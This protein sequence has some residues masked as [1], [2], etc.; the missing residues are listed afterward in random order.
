MKY[1]V[2]SQ[3]PAGGIENIHLFSSSLS[4][5]KMAQNICGPHFKQRIVAAGRVFFEESKDEPTI[6]YCCGESAT[7]GIKSRNDVDTA[8]LKA[9][10]N[11]ME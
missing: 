11:A 9:T 6:M 8:L 7:L 3:Y 1:I 4:H 10:L 2:V 5:D